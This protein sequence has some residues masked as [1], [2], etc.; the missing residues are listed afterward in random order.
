MSKISDLEQISGAN[1]KSNDLFVMVSLDQ[2][3]D[4]T[5]SITRDELLKALQ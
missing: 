1:T 2:G 3:D 4:G 5:R